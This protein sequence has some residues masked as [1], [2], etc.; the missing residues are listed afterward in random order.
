M[1]ISGAFVLQQKS[2]NL[3]R[4]LLKLKFEPDIVESIKI[5]LPR[6]FPDNIFFENHDIRLQLYHVL[7]AYAHHNKEVGYCQGLNYIAGLIL[8]VTK[9]DEWTFWLLKIILDNIVSSYHTKTMY[10]LKVD[11]AV[12]RELIVLRVPEVNKR[13]EDLGMAR[14]EKFF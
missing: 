10:G 6:T 4:D 5:D 13:L 3:Y 9:N 8:I 1:H 2:P 12:L 14:Y 11:T 7:V